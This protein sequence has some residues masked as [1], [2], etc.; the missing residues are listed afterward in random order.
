VSKHRTAA[1]GFDGIEVESERG[2]SSDVGRPVAHAAH[3]SVVGCVVMVAPG[4]HTD[5]Q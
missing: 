5:A 4:H 3:I 2:T 1:V